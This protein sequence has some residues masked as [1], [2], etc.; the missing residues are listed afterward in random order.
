MKNKKSGCCKKILA[1][2]SML[3]LTM[4]VGVYGVGQG[5]RL[6]ADIMGFINTQNGAPTD[7]NTITLSVVSLPDSGETYEVDGNVFNFVDSLDAFIT[8]P[9]DISRIS[10]PGVIESYSFKQDLHSGDPGYNSNYVITWESVPGAGTDSCVEIITDFGISVG[11]CSETFNYFQSAEGVTTNEIAI[12]IFNFFN[13]RPEI[14]AINLVGSTFQLEYASLGDRADI[15]STATVQSTLTKIGDG[16]GHLYRTTNEI[17][18]A[19][20]SASVTNYSVALNLANEVVFT[21]NPVALGVIPIVDGTAGKISITSSYPGAPATREIFEFDVTETSSTIF[22]GGTYD[23]SVTGDIA[24]SA[25][26][27]VDITDNIDVAAAKIHGAIDAIPGLS[28][29]FV[30]NLT[31]IEFTVTGDILGDIFTF[32]IVYTPTSSSS[33]GGNPISY[34]FFTD[35]IFGGTDIYT[36]H[37][38]A[39]ENGGA[40]YDNK[41]VCVNSAD[42]SGVFT[43]TLQNED[44]AASEYR[45]NRQEENNKEVLYAVTGSNGKTEMYFTLNSAGVSGAYSVKNGEVS[46]LSVANKEGDVYTIAMLPVDATITSGTVSVGGYTYAVF[47]G[48]TIQF[49]PQAASGGSGGEVVMGGGADSGWDVDNV[50]MTIVSNAE[51]NEGV[52]SAAAPEA[53]KEYSST[54][55]ASNVLVKINGGS[56]NFA[57]ITLHTALGQYLNNESKLFNNVNLQVQQEDGG[58]TNVAISANTSF[59]E[60]GNGLSNNY[61][62]VDN[63]M[64]IVYQLALDIRGIFTL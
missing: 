39:A 11:L 37:G 38:A 27:I 44:C 15:T 32:N 63:I 34:P 10:V 30:K 41:N 62:F 64:T 51:N 35:V 20:A 54:L 24:A 61:A 33:P 22:Y 36:T 7:P 28:A 2:A 21:S 56:F 46:E 8:S 3:V 14:N 58:V 53:A 18:A 1:V 59:T 57:D 6:G 17:A 19:M 31:T 5:E 52:Y 12:L 60:K 42:A 16:A 45:A 4:L 55:F 49:Q 25:Q 48:Q 9:F 43:I 40:I 23:I 29:S 26:V 50:V 13:T 47:P